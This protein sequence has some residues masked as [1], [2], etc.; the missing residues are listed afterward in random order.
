[1]TAHASRWLDE[2][3]KDLRVK[4][5]HEVSKIARNFENELDIA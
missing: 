2:R 1:V 3:V 5:T 4:I